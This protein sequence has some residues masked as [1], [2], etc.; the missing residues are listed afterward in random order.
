MSSATQSALLTT[1]RRVRRYHRHETGGNGPEDL[2]LPIFKFASVCLRDAES[3]NLPFSQVIG[4]ASALK[5]RRN[6]CLT[7]APLKQTASK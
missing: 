1:Q 2:L 5:L 4:Q 6:T 7:V 3:E